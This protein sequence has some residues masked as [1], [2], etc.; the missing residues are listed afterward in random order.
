MSASGGRRKLFAVITSL[1][2]IVS[3]LPAG[4]VSAGTVTEAAGNTAS[5]DTVPEVSMDGP[6]VV[7]KDQAMERIENF[8]TPATDLKTAKDR[9][10]S[11]LNDS[12]AYYQDPT[13]IGDQ[14]AFIRDA[15]AL[16]ALTDFEETNQSKRLDQIIELVAT[17]DNQ[18]ARRVIRDAEYAFA[19]T[20]ADLGPGMTS[21]VEAHIDNARRQLKRAEQIRERAAEESGAQSIRTTA[22]SVRTYGSAVNQAH[23]ALRM[24]DG[25]VGPEVTL[26]RRTDPIRNG[27]ER[28]QYTLVG[29]VTNPT[30]LDATNVTVTINDDRAVPLALRG[31]YANA[32]FA[33]TINLTERVNTI[34][35][36][37]VETDDGQQS[38]NKKKSKQKGKKKG[39]EKTN[40]GNSGV[41]SGQGQASTVVLR[42]DGDGLP[43]TYEKDVTKTDPLDPDSNSGL[44]NADDSDDGIIDGVEDFDDDNLVAYYEYFYGAS[45]TDP[46]TDGD[47]LPDGYEFI[48]TTTPITQADADGDGTDDGHEDLDGDSL[49]N[50]E[51]MEYGTDP[52]VSDG[53]DDSLNDSAEV[54][55]HDTNVSKPD[56][57]EDGLLDGEEVLLG[58]D[59]LN[60]D[61]DSD[62][63]VDGNETYTQTTRDTSTGI[64][65]QAS[66]P[67]VSSRTVEITEIPQPDLNDTFRAAPV[68]HITGDDSISNATIRIPINSSQIPTNSSNMSIYKWSPE[69]SQPWH[70]IETQIN[71]TDNVAIATADSFSYF[72]VFNSDQWR[73][74]VAP[75]VTGDDGGDGTTNIDTMMVLDTSGSMSGQKIASARDSGKVFVGALENEDAG[76]L[77]GFA[78]F[79]DLKQELTTDY[80]AINESI[81]QLRAGGGTNIGD[82]I[83]T[84]L[85]ELN[86]N[87]VE[88]HSQNLVLLSDGH[89]SRREFALSQADAAADDD[90]TIHTVAVGNNADESLL[91][92]ISSTTGGEFFKTVST[93]GMTEIFR[94]L[95]KHVGREDTDD[96][97]IPNVVENATLTL[98]SGVTPGAE[99][100]MEYDD[101]DSDDDGLAD[102]AEIVD[103]N[104]YTS[105]TEGEEVTRVE[106]TEVTANPDDPNTDGIGLNDSEEIEKGSD[107]LVPEMMTIGVD[108]ATY[109]IDT[110]EGQQP[111]KTG[112]ESA[113]GA[114][115]TWTDEVGDYGSMTTF[116]NDLILAHQTIHTKTSG[117]PII[118]PSKTPDW[119]DEYDL[120]NGQTYIRIPAQV[121]FQSNS[122]ARRYTSPDRFKIVQSFQSPVEENTPILL[123]PSP[124]EGVTYPQKYTVE[125]SLPDQGSQRVNLVFAVEESDWGD[126]E[127]VGEK[128]FT[129][130][131]DHIGKLMVSVPQIT[132]PFSRGSGSVY[133]QGVPYSFA[134]SPGMQRTAQ[135]VERSATVYE[136]GM[137]IATAATSGGGPTV[138]LKEWA[139]DQLDPVPGPAEL[140]GA[141]IRMFASEVEDMRTDLQEDAISGEDTIIMMMGPVIVRAN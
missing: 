120:K 11:R 81:D 47:G 59:P 46:D 68:V 106:L 70:S 119:L 93:D 61:S 23:T 34:E 133:S 118:A 7:L 58:T 97:G 19:A 44:T 82:G 66:G 99:I 1:L 80:D 43:G 38:N 55:T 96:D 41:S 90:V 109:G 30:G 111:L 127:Q 131:Y 20:E 102:G 63:T 134:G 126:P 75:V 112:S 138:I 85:A 91:Q 12:F 108:V 87:G 86:R 17:A 29:N 28:A 72:S 77:V 26:T 54:E 31:D 104:I 130:A 25:E 2:M 18:S 10:R 76:G 9:A 124:D 33:K 115:D 71:R 105:G 74:R 39:K 123:D 79:A 32:T 140:E 49:T 136:E 141:A 36:T 113:E 60:P 42:L 84:G 121:Y 122:H 4:T 89:T 51:E 114:P 5:A 94:K 117:I 135:M 98:L 52:L 116:D 101:P 40:N 137:S 48:E 27:S 125:G 69:D 95:G 3:I 62:G 129:G 57:D 103:Y 56:T 45:P 128:Y 107:P 67:G 8:T 78:S 65:V 15:E 73:E 13:R 139:E 53:D 16:R 92:E 37:A 88:D 83:E 24:I 14:H 110:D 132:G 21:S 6:P 50:I 35:I 100:D 22:R 64:S